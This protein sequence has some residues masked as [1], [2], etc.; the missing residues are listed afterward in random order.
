MAYISTPSLLVSWN[1]GALW[2]PHAAAQRS[3]VGRSLGAFSSIS[4]RV[5]T[6]N[7][8]VVDPRDEQLEAGVGIGKKAWDLEN[9]VATVTKNSL[10]I[11]F[12]SSIQV[13]NRVPENKL[14]RVQLDSS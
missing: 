4:T 11:I 6:A 1:P 14:L 2:T 13:A 10:I 5:L 3:I 12:A 8:F 7:N 9:V